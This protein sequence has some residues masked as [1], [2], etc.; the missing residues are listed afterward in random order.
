YEKSSPEKPAA[1]PIRRIAAPD[2]DN[3]IVKIKDAGQGLRKEEGVRIPFTFLVIVSG[4]EKRER[5][6]LKIIRNQHLFPR[7]K[8]EFVTDSSK[9]NPNGLLETAKDKRE[10]Y[11]TSTEVPDD[12]FIV[13]DVDHFM[14]ELLFIKPECEK[15]NISL[16]ISNSCFE[17]WLYYVKFKDKPRDFSI[18]DDPLKISQSF[19]KY[20]DGK[21]KGGIDPRKVIFNICENIENAKANYEED[22]NGI[23]KLFSTNMFLLAEALLP[24]IEAELIREKN[25]RERKA[26]KKNVR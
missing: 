18:P 15:L 26:K 19:K 23:P 12:I 9:L 2:K 6:Y 20:I 1:E 4:G 24:F 5:D 21:I 14:D 10:R 13:S 3:V 7:I 22:R 17:V 8:I 11:K 16:I 25:K